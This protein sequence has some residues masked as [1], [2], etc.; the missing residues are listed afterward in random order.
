MTNNSK[1]ASK[2]HI[3][4]SVFPPNILSIYDSGNEWCVCGTG[5]NILRHF[6]GFHESIA[7][8]IHQRTMQEIALSYTL[9]LL[10]LLFVFLL[11]CCL[12]Q[13]YTI[14][15]VLLLLLLL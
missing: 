5:S 12:S 7:T 2:E 8:E 13:F 3:A 11:I 1:E 4:F 15:S 10:L 9:L 14:L 6:T